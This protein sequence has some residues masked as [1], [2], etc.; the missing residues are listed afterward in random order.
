MG[1][2]NDQNKK[3]VEDHIFGLLKDLKA[4]RDG[5]GL[6][7]DG[8]NWLGDAATAHFDQFGAIDLRRVI[9]LAA[10]ARGYA[11]LR[12]DYPHPNDKNLSWLQ[13]V[14]DIRE[15]SVDV[16]RRYS[17]PAAKGEMTRDS[18]GKTLNQRFNDRVL[19]LG[20]N[21][22]HRA[23]EP[24][25]TEAV[26]PLTEQEKKAAAD[27]ANIDAIRK[28]IDDTPSHSKYA[29]SQRKRLHARL[30]ELL[31]DRNFKYRN[32]YTQEI[33]TG[34]DAVKA[35]MRRELADKDNPIH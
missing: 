34:L 10:E 31:A 15:A 20:Q 12:D 26:K 19:W 35:E 33:L 16:M 14:E 21:N 7:K 17:Q 8:I 32:R 9:E 23:Q 13:S 3:A 27:K 18:S 6:N 2:L 28:E 25:T 5:L 4:M 24:V 11:V 1:F 29:D 22:V 30:N